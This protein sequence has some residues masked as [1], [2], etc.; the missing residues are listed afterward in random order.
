MMSAFEL[1][2]TITSICFIPLLIA[3]FF[4]FKWVNSLYAKLDLLRTDRDSLH[5]SVCHLEDA[6]AKR[7][8]A[9]YSYEKDYRETDSKLREL[10]CS[11][12][13]QAL[14]ALENEYLEV[15]TQNNRYKK[16]LVQLYPAL[17]KDND[18]NDTPF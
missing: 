2:P 13:H 12:P 14:L 16:F 10:I 18:D 3:F 9:M 11:D 6:L 1:I 17:N 8:E 5:T 15:L 7:T 4:M